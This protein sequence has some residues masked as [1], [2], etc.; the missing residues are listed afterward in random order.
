MSERA[1]VERALSEH[2]SERD[3]TF[4]DWLSRRQQE[5]QELD[6]LFLRAKS[7]GLK[8][9]EIAEKLNGGC[10][11]NAREGGLVSAAPEWSPQKV[12]RRMREAEQIA[13]SAVERLIREAGERRE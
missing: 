13:A 9:G 2:A 10:Q 6:V 5:D 12:A 11:A 4:R 8:N 7:A 1:E 3:A